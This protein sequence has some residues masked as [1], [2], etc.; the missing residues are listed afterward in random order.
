MNYRKLYENIIREEKIKLIIS[1][2]AQQCGAKVL[3]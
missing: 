3:N 2:S 1:T